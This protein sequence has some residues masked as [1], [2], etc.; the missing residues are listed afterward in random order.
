[1]V[2]PNKDE[3]NYDNGSNYNEGFD[4][5]LYT[6]KD[7]G[8]CGSDEDIACENCGRCLHE[9]NLYVGTPNGTLCEAC[10]KDKEDIVH[11]R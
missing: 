6:G 3:I 8:K 1:M 9:V 5:Y 4:G 2:R 10:I 11:A 7:A